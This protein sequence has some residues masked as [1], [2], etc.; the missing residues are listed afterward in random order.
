MIRRL[1]A[2]LA[3]ALFASVAAAQ[4]AQW[5]YSAVPG[6]N[7]KAAYPGDVVIGGSCTGCGG[8]AST[9]A[10]NTWIATQTFNSGAS[11][12]AVAFRNIAEV[13]NTTATA[14]PA[15]T[16]YDLLSQAVQF[17]TVNA[18]NNWTLNIRGDASNTL[19][20]VLPLGQAVTLALITTQGAT[21]F[22]ANVV[23]IDGVT[24]TPKWQGG[25]APAAGNASGLDVYTFTVI[26]T[27]V[28]TYTVLAS[29]VQFK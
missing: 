24:V 7:S 28:S 18:A 2:G 22:F 12:L 9:T 6:Q 13:A 3:L 11:S 26:K 25:T 20:T 4:P 29:L 17:Y 21:P 1:L 16:N 10:P 14:P 15:T 8:G 5:N 27:G 19:N 23:Q